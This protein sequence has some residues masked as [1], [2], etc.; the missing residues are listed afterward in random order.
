MKDKLLE[1]QD[2]Q[3]D[4]AD[5]SRKAHPMI[6]IGDKVWLLRRNL[7]TNRLC[8]K[9]DFHHLGPF[10]I[11]KQINDVAFRLELPPSM[12]IHPVFHVSLLELYK[13]SSIPGRFHVPPPP[14]E[15]NGQ[16]EFEVSEILDSRIIQ[17]K[18][19][20]LVQWHGYNNLRNAPEMIQEFHCWYPEKP[21]SKDA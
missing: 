12:K 13:E 16:E 21:S 20:Y 5:M 4:N 6:N 1:A 11:I 19:E 3:K 15:L 18:L 14:V 2:W 8:D 10:S 9:L 17:R 7:K